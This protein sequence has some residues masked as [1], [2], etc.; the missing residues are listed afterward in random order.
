MP[1]KSSLPVP[2]LCHL[3]ISLARG[4]HDPSNSHFLLLFFSFLLIGDR[5][6]GGFLVTSRMIDMFKGP[7]DPPNYSPLLYTAGMIFSTINVTIHLLN[8][9]ISYSVPGG[10]FSAGYLAAIAAGHQDLTHLAYLF[11]SICCIGSIGGLASQVTP[12]QY[13]CILEHD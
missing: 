2:C 5:F 11:P 1:P 7:M 3:L 9:V 13:I 10:V 8:H 6:T 12:A 4:L